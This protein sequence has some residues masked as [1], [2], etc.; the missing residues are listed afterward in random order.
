MNKSVARGGESCPYTYNSDFVN[1]NNRK[2]GDNV[3][4]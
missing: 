2:T 3:I 1:S 4:I